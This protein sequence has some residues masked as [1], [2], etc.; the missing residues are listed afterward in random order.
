MEGTEAG[1]MYRRRSHDH[2]YQSWDG[3]RPRIVIAV[4]CEIAEVPKLHGVCR[5]SRVTGK[6]EVIPS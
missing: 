1:L 6:Q 4:V 5:R 2:V 3:S